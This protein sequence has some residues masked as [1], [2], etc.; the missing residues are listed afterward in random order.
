MEKFNSIRK[1]IFDVIG[2]SEGGK[3]TFFSKLYGA[4]MLVAILISIIPLTVRTNCNAFNI[5]DKITFVVFV[6]DYILRFATADFKLKRGARSFIRYPFLIMSIID[7][8]SILPSIKVL[9]NGFRLLKMLRFFQ[10]LKVFRAFRFFRYSKN[11]DII[12]NVFRRQKN[13]LII[14]GWLALGYILITALIM[15]NVEPE[16]FKTFFDAIYWA[17]I[18]LTT[19]G[20]GDIYA[21]S[22]LGKI[23]TMFSSLFGIAIV[24]LPAGIITAGYMAEIKKDE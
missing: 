16:T 18:S 1:G 21:V 3:V 11:I 2:A 4:F 7:F 12:K 15:F 14:V 17:T 22:T 8:V 10:M 23:I 5:I 24:A 13:G 20:Y 6:T 9:S 19:V